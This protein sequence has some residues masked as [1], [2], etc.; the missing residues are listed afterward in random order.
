M[1][2]DLYKVV[3]KN[4]LLGQINETG[5]RTDNKNLKVE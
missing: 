5:L 3:N 1:L 4:G 2:L